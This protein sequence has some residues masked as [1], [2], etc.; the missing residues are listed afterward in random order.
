MPPGFGDFSPS[1]S[2]V[3]IQFVLSTTFVDE[4]TMMSSSPLSSLDIISNPKN[5]VLPLLF[6]CLIKVCHFF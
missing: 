4:I 1:K 2:N 3:T 5:N 6:L